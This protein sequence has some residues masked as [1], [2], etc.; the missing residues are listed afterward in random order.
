MES[1]LLNL[2]QKFYLF[3]CLLIYLGWTS[4]DIAYSY[5]YTQKL[6]LEV[7]YTPYWKDK[8]K[9]RLTQVQTLCFG[10]YLS[11][12]FILRKNKQIYKFQYSLILSLKGHWY[13]LCLKRLTIPR[14]YISL[15]GQL[16]I[17]NPWN[18]LILLKL[19]ILGL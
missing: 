12:K 10:F 3:L 2:S 13:S 14:K 5:I 1:N 8:T 9:P 4:W 15:N 18:C 7:I 6:L 11:S 19:F 17:N 16:W